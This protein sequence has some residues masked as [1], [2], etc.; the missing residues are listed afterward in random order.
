MNTASIPL[1][2]ATGNAENATVATY[3][4]EIVIF[5]KRFLESRLNLIH[6]ISLNENAAQKRTNRTTTTKDLIQLAEIVKYNTNRLQE[7]LRNYKLRVLNK[8]KWSISEDNMKLLEEYISQLGALARTFERVIVEAKKFQN[9]K[10]KTEYNDK[11]YTK[12]RQEAY[13][14]KTL[15]AE[16]SVNVDNGLK[17]LIK[18]I[19]PPRQYAK[20]NESNNVVGPGKLFGNTDGGRRRTHKHRHS[21]RRHTRRN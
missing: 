21:R 12:I 16:A 2:S 10:I 13:T 3:A 6:A 9:G 8:G 7:S 5:Y 18:E 19:L 11:K 15:G 4:N 14:L 20:L 17:K 1:L